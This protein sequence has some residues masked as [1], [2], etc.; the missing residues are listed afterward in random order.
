MVKRTYPQNIEV[1]E[2]SNELKKIY[3]E[4]KSKIWKRIHDDILKPTR[5]RREVNLAKLERYC[6]DDDVIVIPGKLL[7]TGVLT[8]KI[9]IAPMLIS[10]KTKEK[11]SNSNAKLMS[12]IELAKKNPKGT[13][14]RIIG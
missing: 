8:K 2:T 3:T 14:V 1:L 6:T 13:K 4:K 5:K 10:N 7:G 11:L 12:I 9:T